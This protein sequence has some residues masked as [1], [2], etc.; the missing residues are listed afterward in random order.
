V[1]TAVHLHIQLLGSLRVTVNDQPVRSLSPRPATL[2]AHLALAPGY[3][4]HR[5]WLMD[6]L[7]PELYLEAQGNNLNVT[8][9]S[10]RK[11]LASA[12]APPRTFLTRDGDMVVLAP[13]DAVTVD[14]T[15]FDAAVDHAWRK[16]DPMVTQAAVDLYTGDLLPEAP[17]D[18]QL[19]ARRTTL[20]TSAIT[21]LVRLGGQHA[22]RGSVDAAIAAFSRLAALEPTH[23]DGR[24]ALMRLY[25]VAG[26]PR[27]ALDHYEQLVA[28]LRSDLDAEP[29]ASTYALAEAIRDGNFPETARQ[30]VPMADAAS[31]PLVD[32]QSHG[33]LPTPL[34]DLIGRQRE[35]AEV[36]QLLAIR[37]LVTIIGPG[38]VGKTRLAIAVG[39]QCLDATGDTVVFVDL[40]PFRDPMLVLPSIAT[41]LGI[42]ESGETP[43]INVLAMAL[44]SRRTLLILDNFE[45]VI[46]AA[47]DVI[48]LISACPQLAVLATSREPL[49]VR[50]E[51]QYP[52]APLPLPD[53][54]QVA[55]VEWLR[56]C[57][58][59]ALFIH[60]ARDV[61]PDFDLTVEN[62]ATVNAI[63]QRLNGLPLAIELAAAWI[64]VH[65]PEALLRHL[66]EP[67]RVLTGGARDLPDR[68][69]TIYD[70][71]Q[72]SY[73]L[74]TEDEQRLFNRL[75][76][77]AGG[78]SLESAGAIANHDGH[79]GIDLLIGLDSLIG[80]SLVVRDEAPD[81]SVRFS[82]L[83]LLREFGIERVYETGDTDA[84]L[85][86][87]RH[88]LTLVQDAE[89]GLFGPDQAR[90]AE[91]VARDYANIRAALGWS[92]ATDKCDIALQLAGSLRPYWLT[93]DR[94]TEGRYWFD[95]VLSIAGDASP[96]WRAKA[97]FGA[98]RMAGEQGDYSAADRYLEDAVSCYRN[99]GDEQ[100]MAFALNGRGIHAGYAGDIE[101]AQQYLHQSLRL[102]ETVGD[103]HGMSRSLNNLGWTS[104]DQGDYVAAERWLSQSLAIARQHGQVDNVAS[105]LFN[106]GE[107]AMRRGDHEAARPYLIESLIIATDIGIMRYVAECFEGLAWITGIEGNIE[108]AGR[109]YGAAAALRIAIGRPLSPT[110][111]TVYI[112]RLRMTRSKIDAAE[113]E[114]AWTAGQ[115]L[116]AEEMTAL[117]TATHRHYDSR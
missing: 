31:P 98:G 47:S 83:S 101:Q 9:H 99:I 37:R 13:T 4:L 100:G 11:L 84:F 18:E 26:Q 107:V 68:Q 53:P 92:V 61:K 35:C 114:T 56:D 45:Q 72:W 117:F 34:T 105:A 104:T 106:L 20:R 28:I 12:G 80:K 89:V 77:F 30:L 39:Q 109:A 112:E 85:V 73:D 97:L 5:E 1:T 44:R 93:H 24:V 46:D 51:A 76:V 50:G 29:Q 15:V 69:R 63:C 71:I 25:A 17:Y 57:P 33:N 62:V 78:S 36:V 102:F 23:E 41:T 108:L 110:E 7:W 70:T 115:A 66:N 27:A 82:L 2:L 87:A 6:A 48:R 19:D 58:T 94:Y 64:R 8:L 52:I 81:G 116:T 32:V 10:L 42:R 21:V 91:R 22:A 79:L 54:A 65:S 55:A 74:L 103:L 96:A 59:V 67:L 88:M 49:R 75:T 16:D 60:R 43:L 113:W 90:F 111:N 40:S 14:I 3:R 38:G 95:A 86:H